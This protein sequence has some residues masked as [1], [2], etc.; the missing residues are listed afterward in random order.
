MRHVEGVLKEPEGHTY[1]P[2]AVPHPL[3][4]PRESWGLW[5][6]GLEEARRDKAWLRGLHCILKE[7]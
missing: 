2:P 3:P 5:Q 4:V 7:P 1:S 6:P